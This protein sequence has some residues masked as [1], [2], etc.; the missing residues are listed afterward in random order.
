MATLQPNVST[1]SIDP[2]TRVGIVALTVA[3][4][5]RSL[6]FYTGAIGLTVVRRNGSDAILGAAGTPLLLL[7][8]QPGALPWMIDGMTGLYHFAILVPTRVTLGRWLHH[9]LT[10]DYPP[11]GQGDHIVSEALYLRDP[12][13][14]GIEVYADR[15]REGW[16]WLN[17]QVRMGGGPIDVRG[18]LAEAHRAREPWTGLPAGTVLGHVHLQ[19]GDIAQADA[20]Y[21]GALGF[22]VVA[23]M[24]QAL[25]VSAGGY[26]HHL[27]LNVWH[28]QGAAPAPTDLATLQFFTLT[29]PS[30][31]TLADVAARLAAADLSFQ[32]TA[33]EIAAQDPWQNLVILHSGPLATAESVET[34][35]ALK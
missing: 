20:F 2:A 4:L 30:A 13:G 9:Y 5:D 18:L 35:A 12:D 32:Q 24:T 16:Q 27:G 19:V 34:V 1:R 31:A 14:H 21:H 10:L 8:E 6:A 33:N 7:R 11:P 3:S 17:G 28:S 26:H 29:V 23:R 22:D 25:F 15:P